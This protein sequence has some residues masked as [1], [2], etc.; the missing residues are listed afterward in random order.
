MKFDFTKK[1]DYARKI[2]D[3]LKKIEAMLQKKKIFH[4]ILIN[5]NLCENNSEKV[6]SKNIL[7]FKFN[8]KV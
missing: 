6:R 1:V 2:E 8:S 4:I 7:D 3:G 5:I